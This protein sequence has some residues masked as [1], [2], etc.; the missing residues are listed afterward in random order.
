MK[1]IVR[2]LSVLLIVLTL[3]LLVSCKDKDDKDDKDEIVDYVSQVKLEESFEGKTF[4]KDGIEEVTLYLAVD[5]DTIHVLNKEG[6]IL[7]LRFLGVDTPEST[8]QVDPWGMAASA[9]TKN[10]VKNCKSIVIT[11]DGGP[12]T[13]DTL[14]L[15]HI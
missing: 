9:F 15:I 13:R 1:K 10:I 14:S 3:G 11:S 4:I 6:T 12:G 8:A 2:I 5:G 7:Q